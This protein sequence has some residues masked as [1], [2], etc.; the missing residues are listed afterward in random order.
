MLRHGHMYPL[1]ETGEQQQEDIKNPIQTVH[2]ADY[3]KLK[4]DKIERATNYLTADKD[5]ARTAT[6][7][8]RHGVQVMRRVRGEV[9]CQVLNS[10]APLRLEH[11]LNVLLY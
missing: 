8:R 7:L 10:I 11:L 4:K 2:F 9:R 1:G 6:L 3:A 5:D